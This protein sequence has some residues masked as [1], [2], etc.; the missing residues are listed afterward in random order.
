MAPKSGQKKA[1]KLGGEGSSFKG[2]V[3]TKG[4]GKASTNS[5]EKA[6]ENHDDRPDYS[7]R[8]HGQ[9]ETP[10]DDS[11]SLLAD[12]LEERLQPFY[13]VEDFGHIADWDNEAGLVGCAF[14]DPAPVMSALENIGLENPVD[15]FGDKRHRIIFKIARGI[16]NRG[17]ALDLIT[18]A[19]ALKTE[20]NAKREKP[21]VVAMEYISALMEK[22]PSPGNYSYYLSTVLDRHKARRKR[23]LMLAQDRLENENPNGAGDVNESLDS[24]VAEIEKIRSVG[25]QKK[26]TIHFAKWNEITSYEIPEGFELLGDMTLCRGEMS[27][28]AGYPG[29]G[30]SMAALWLAALAATGSGEFM[31]HD[32]LSQFRTLYIQDENGLIPLQQRLNGIQGRFPD[33]DFSNW[34]R[35]SEPPEDGMA[36]DNPEFRREI[37]N[38]IRDF[39]PGLVIIDP[40]TNLTNDTGKRDYS[41]ALAHIRA[42]I[43]PRIDQPAIL[44]VTHCRKKSPNAKKARGRALLH[45]IMGSQVIVSKARSIWGLDAVSDNGDDERVVMSVIKNSNGIMPPPTAHLR[46]VGWFED[47]QDFDMDEYYSDEGGNGGSGNTKDDKAWRILSDISNGDPTGFNKWHEA[48]KAEGVYKGKASFNESV[49]RLRQANRIQ[50]DAASKLYQIVMEDG[51]F[52]D[53]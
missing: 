37:K 35:I 45:E 13:G 10:V 12:P 11:K 25:P 27:L 19:S 5:A 9:D 51:A 38:Q 29:T 26:K 49:K 3:P 42:M 23:R 31:G 47:I 32:I 6:S 43:P 34:I 53:D 39:D 14:L 20:V 36:I 52:S 21:G 44:V 33:F 16:S 18:F 46:G 4:T 1:P 48:C 22:V 24:L 50:Q 40:F 41:E 17:G 2:G 15:L 28:I 8:H 7:S 30:K